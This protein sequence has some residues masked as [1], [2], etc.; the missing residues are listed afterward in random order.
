MRKIIFNIKFILIFLI[1]KIYNDECDNNYRILPYNEEKIFKINNL[2]KTC[3]IIQIE[4]QETP[5][6]EQTYSNCYFL[7]STYQNPRYIL[8]NNLSLKYLITYD[9]STNQIYILNGYSE[10]EKIIN[11]EYSLSN[12]LEIISDEIFVIIGSKM[13]TNEYTAGDIN[14]QHTLLFV[15]LANPDYGER[16]VLNPDFYFVHSI[17]FSLFKMNNGILLLVSFNDLGKNDPSIK[18][19]SI[20]FFFMNLSDYSIERKAFF[21]ISYDYKYNDKEKEMK[22]IELVENNIHYIILCYFYNNPLN[23]STYNVI[24]Y[25]QKYMNSNLYFTNKE[26]L[27]YNCH[28]EYAFYL[29][30][31][32]NFGFISCKS[33]KDD[34][35]G[36]QI[37]KFY[38]NLTTVGYIP[39]RTDKPFHFIPLQNYSLFYFYCTEDNKIREQ[40][41]IVPE[42]IDNIRKSINNKE[43]ISYSFLQPLYLPTYLPG[44]SQYQKTVITVSSTNLNGALNTPDNLGNI[45]ELNNYESQDITFEYYLTIDYQEIIESK[46]ITFT[47]QSKNCVAD[48]ILC[49]KTC[50]SCFDKG[51]DTNH[52]CLKCQNEY[53]FNQSNITGNC[54]NQN[55]PGFYQNTTELLLCYKT[56]KYCSSVGDSVNHNCKS[57]DTEK[58]YYP[59]CNSYPTDESNTEKKCPDF[60]QN[61]NGNI[62]PFNCHFLNETL[63][64]FYFNKECKCFDECSDNCIKCLNNTYC[65]DCDYEIDFYLYYFK[66]NNTYVCDTYYNKIKEGK[67]L[68]GIR[69]KYGE[70]KNCYFTCG[71]CSEK[72]NETNNNCD[73]CDDTNYF[74]NLLNPK[75][76]EC[77]NYNFKNDLSKCYESY[78]I[79]TLNEEGKECKFI[80]RNSILDKGICVDDCF[81]TENKF[82]FND[83]CFEK[84]PNG[85]TFKIDEKKCEDDQICSLNEYTTTIPLKV[86][87]EDVMNDI[88]LSYFKEYGQD[89]KHIKVIYSED[90]TYNISLYSSQVCENDIYYN[91]IPK[92]DLSQC[93][94]LIK[95]EGYNNYIVEVLSIFKGD[96][97]PYQVKYEIYSKVTGKNKLNS[98]IHLCTEMTMLIYVPMNSIRKV[99]YELAKELYP[100]INLFNLSDPFFNDICY[101]YTDKFNKE[102]TLRDR[103]YDY[104]INYTY[105]DDYC[106]EIEK[107]FSTSE[108]LCECNILKNQP[109][110]FKVK[111]KI[112]TDKKLVYFNFDCLLCI[113]K[114][115]G[116]IIK[117]FGLL[118]T[119]LLLLIH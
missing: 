28:T 7:K 116:N 27:L 53:F 32:S 68:D 69:F 73:R 115:F 20:T 66:E 25:S 101:Y 6:P 98:L 76:C 12:T 45:V 114:G 117:N 70:F 39:K 81:N 3:N 86:I 83:Q 23:D 34:I 18:E 82:V 37:I 46:K 33:K 58:N 90:K 52:N 29:Y 40:K 8:D 17:F 55:A 77:K 108:V 106:V 65:I 87:N 64:F 49:Y 78:A 92:I 26:I 31:I 75:N 80:Y 11:F 57:C 1:S 88:A 15:N 89:S 71:G 62:N 24:C 41:V 105:C 91:F 95:S 72:G 35:V 110:N 42:C 54:L 93:I 56:C 22:I 50:E 16:I 100:D 61:S 59:L 9:P 14:F 13:I 97:L 47:Y 79:T 4:N 44:E 10:P 99:N 19:L 43:T 119:L 107:S 51:N 21:D 109:Y 84:C 94:S 113:S 67:Y 96:Y 102:I 112:P 2:T 103:F 5:T 36:Y 60:S 85:T 48:I 104:Y 63:D 111:E 74:P 38:S 30:N 118:F